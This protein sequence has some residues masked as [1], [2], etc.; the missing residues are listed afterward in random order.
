MK[1]AVTEKG[2]RK[3]AE[4]S[5]ISSKRRFYLD[6]FNL[7]YRKKPGVSRLVSKV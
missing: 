2:F 7:H 4:L 5:S 6:I 1:K 3:A